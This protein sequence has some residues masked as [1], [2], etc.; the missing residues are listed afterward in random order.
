[1]QF[2]K[3]AASAAG[4]VVGLYAGYKA[5]VAIEKYLNKREQEAVEK[6]AAQATGAS[7]SAAA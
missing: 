2:F 6:T 4:T 3:S 1:M 5:V 7:S